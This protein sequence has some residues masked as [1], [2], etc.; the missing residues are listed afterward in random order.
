MRRKLRSHR[1][2]VIRPQGG[3]KCS[4]RRSFPHP[5]GIF[6]GQAGLEEQFELSLR[7]ISLGSLILVREVGIRFKREIGKRC[8]RPNAAIPNVAVV[9]GTGCRPETSTD[10]SDLFSKASLIKASLGGS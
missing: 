6:A 10:A 9:V 3:E 1:A 7:S 5:L 8:D 2:W 4:R